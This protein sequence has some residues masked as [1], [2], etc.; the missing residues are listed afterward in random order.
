MSMAT[1]LGF[2]CASLGSRVSAR[3]GLVALE[4]AFDEGI[5]WFDLAPSYGDGH[6]ETV[7]SSFAANHR[8]RLRILTKVGIAPARPHLAARALR[9]IARRVI[10]AFPQARRLAA[11]G[12][13]AATRL[14]LTG[15]LII[16]SMEASLKRLRVE[17]VHVCALHDPDPVSLGRDDVARA[18]E[19]IVV[20]GLAEKTGIAGSP[21]ASAAALA[22]NLPIGLVQV[23]DGFGMSGLDWLEPH[24]NN[25]SLTR[26][27]HSHLS[28]SAPNLRTMISEREDGSAL[29]ERFGYSEPIAIS[30]RRAALD[31]ARV[32][33]PTGQLLLAAFKTSHLKDNLAMLTDDLS[34]DPTG[35]RAALS[36]TPISR[37]L[38]T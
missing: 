37:P 9:P 34:G 18:L 36:D 8:G 31:L 24:L 12:R 6:A 4:C 29:L 26:V 19:E 21:E 28:R 14:P 11:R 1:R 17:S 38:D 32:S 2:G 10:D 33:N 16:T 35:L 22:A 13:D 25:P 30:S 20:R 3:D 15:S 23:A 5:T 27:T 7:F